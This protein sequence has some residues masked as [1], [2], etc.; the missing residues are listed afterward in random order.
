M[1][2][3]APFYSGDKSSLLFVPGLILNHSTLDSLVFNHQK[4]WDVWRL[5]NA[6]SESNKCIKES[7]PKISRVINL[8]K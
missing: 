8:N 3:Y 5:L 7:F 2:Q 4:R 1:L 6:S